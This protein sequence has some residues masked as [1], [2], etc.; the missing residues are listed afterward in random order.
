MQIRGEQE[1][2]NELVVREIGEILAPLQRAI[3]LAIVPQP[4][5]PLHQR[6]LHIPPASSTPAGP[7]P[8]QPPIHPLLTARKPG[9]T[10]PSPAHPQPPCQWADHDNAD[11]NRHCTRRRR[12]S[13][14]S[15]DYVLSGNSC[16]RSLRL[17]VGRVGV[18][19]GGVWWRSRSREWRG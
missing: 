10:T 4:D 5:R 3:S 1:V 11:A 15:P 12:R 7:L 8:L 13:H 18:G 2:G 6:D 9:K 14:C 19:V 17:L 16:R